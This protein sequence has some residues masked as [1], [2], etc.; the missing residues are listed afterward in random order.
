MK[1]RITL[2]YGEIPWR[3][4]GGT[5]DNIRRLKMQRLNVGFSRAKDIM[6]FVHSMPIGDYT[7]SRLGDALQHYEKIRSAAHDHYV[8]DES[9]FGS[10]AEKHL[11]SLI[12]QTPFFAEH[13]D[14][15][16][17]VAQFEIGKYIRQ[18]Y[19]R[20]NDDTLGLSQGAT[21]AGQRLVELTV[22]DLGTLAGPPDEGEGGEAQPDG[23]EVTPN[24]G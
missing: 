14:K 16:R 19:K 1:G 21:Q 4:I 3:S 24:G 20:Y 22:D 13:R 5:A 2:A 12:V 6:V 23:M 10:P 11:Y 18:E 17:L 7:D 9:V 8:E 15:L